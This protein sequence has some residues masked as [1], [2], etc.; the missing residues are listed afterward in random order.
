[1]SGVAPTSEQIIADA[2]LVPPT[3][4]P[5]GGAPRGRY[6]STSARSAST[7]RSPLIVVLFDDPHRRRA[8][9]AAEHLQHHRAELATS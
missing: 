9:A 4:V 7:S 8:A 3:A 1:M 6:R 5:G 2:M